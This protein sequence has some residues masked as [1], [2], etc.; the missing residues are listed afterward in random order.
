MLFCLYIYVVWTLCTIKLSFTGGIK[1]IKQSNAYSYINAAAAIVA[2]A[3]GVRWSFEAIL[4][5]DNVIA[6]T[7]RALGFLVLSSWRTLYLG[8]SSRD[9]REI[10]FFQCS[11]YRKTL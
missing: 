4:S 3:M 2:E 10:S 1:K 11:V 5:S 7:N 9:M 6:Y 8:A